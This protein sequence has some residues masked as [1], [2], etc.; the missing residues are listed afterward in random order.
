M[1]RKSDDPESKNPT[2]NARRSSAGKRRQTDR[3]LFGGTRYERDDN[4]KGK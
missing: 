3:K 2:G 1:V 4:K